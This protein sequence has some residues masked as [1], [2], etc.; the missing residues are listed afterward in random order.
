[1]FE[2]AHRED[3]VEPRA[4]DGMA[5]PL[6]LVIERL[7]TRSNVVEVAQ[8]IDIGLPRRAQEVGEIEALD[9]RVGVPRAFVEGM[10]PAARIAH[11]YNGEEGGRQGVMCRVQVP[12]CGGHGGQHFRRKGGKFWR[13]GGVGHCHFASLAAY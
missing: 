2:V 1:M 12:A 3:V 10:R 6:Q 8:F 13:I 11:R 9:G 4:R 5:V 7:Q